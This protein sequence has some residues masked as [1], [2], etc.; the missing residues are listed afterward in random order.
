[1]GDTG[2]ALARDGAAPFLNPATLTNLKNDSLAFS[3]NL[4]S[5]TVAHYSAWHHPGPDDPAFGKLDLPSTSLNDAR[6]DVLPSTFC[7]FFT[8]GTPS[9]S[10]GARDKL[11]VC[12]GAAERDQASY[13]AINYRNGDAAQSQSLS[14]SWQR[15]HAGPSYA[16]ELSKDFAIGASLHGIYTSY[17][18]SWSADT[19]TGT[20]GG[21]SD[22]T[23]FDAA[24]TARSLEL[25]AILGATY[26]INRATTLGLSVQVPTV[27][28]WGTYDASLHTRYDVPGIGAG[29]TSASLLLS[30]HGTF[31]APPPPRLAIGVGTELGRLTVEADLALYAPLDTA[32]K[33]ELLVQSTTVAAQRVANSASNQTFTERA[34]ATIDSGVGAEYFV[35][36][37]FSII[38]GFSA[39][40]SPVPPLRGPL[41][42]SLGTFYQERQN[43]ATLSF[44]VGSYGGSGDLLLGLRATVGH[45]TAYAVNGFALPPQLAVVNKTSVGAIFVVAGNANLETL[46]RTVLRVREIVDPKG[47]AIPP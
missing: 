6:L 35:N 42:P 22:E 8:V 11:A 13:P 39:D 20:Q 28:V 37:S 9:K 1:M 18:L 4:Y 46:E 27:N 14:R 17:D 12:L 40:F 2:V 34:L 26:K 44:G 33:A 3:V 36:R 10:T 45:G 38:G 23:S 43:H 32:L 47:R 29:P 41:A 15:F 7:L 19:L 5:L 16:I 30:G 21:S 31:S 25:G 24:A